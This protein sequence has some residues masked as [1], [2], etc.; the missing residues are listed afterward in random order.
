MC[1]SCIPSY[2]SDISQL[3]RRSRIYRGDV[4]AGGE[5]FV[6]RDYVLAVFL[7]LPQ[8][9]S[10]SGKGKCFPFQLSIPSW[11]FLWQ[12]YLS[13]P[14]EKAFGAVQSLCSRFQSDSGPSIVGKVGN[15][16]RIVVSPTL[17]GLFGPLLEV[18]KWAFRMEHH[19]GMCLRVSWHSPL[20]GALV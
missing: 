2:E 18:R 7:L 15:E 12:P 13:I 1:Q 20:L 9:F 3:V 14:S 11:L 10:Y 6:Q 16:L 19:S 17:C 4:V 5:P 8:P